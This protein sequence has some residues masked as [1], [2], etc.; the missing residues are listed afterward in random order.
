[1]SMRVFVE[2]SAGCAPTREAPPESSNAA[3]TRTLVRSDAFPSALIVSVSLKGLTSLDFVEPH[4]RVHVPF[5]S[6]I[7][8]STPCELVRTP[9]G[10][11]TSCDLQRDIATARACV[12]SSAPSGLA[13][14][15][16]ASLPS[17]VLVQ[18]RSQREGQVIG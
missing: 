6:R 2:S 7:E 9:R 15:Q 13:G 4:A 12:P 8:R 5:Q 17:S 3:T 14:T 10:I 11:S 1:M 18:G 16:H